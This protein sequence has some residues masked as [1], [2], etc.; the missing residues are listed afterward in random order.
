MAFKKVGGQRNY[1]KYSE[2][3]KGDRLV[4]SGVYV[5]SEE[6][7]FGI[8]HLFK[9]KKGAEVT[10][11]NSAGHLNYLL[12]EHCEPGDLVNIDYGGKELLTKGAM[13]GKEAHR[14][15]LE[16][17]DQKHSEAVKASPKLTLTDDDISL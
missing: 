7:K 15:S 13:K 4:D 14:F 3:N 17:D 12:E 10:C 8:Q 5:G 9:I 6:G 16:I 11:L 2:C 1:V